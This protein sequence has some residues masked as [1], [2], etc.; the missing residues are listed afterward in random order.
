MA[1]KPGLGSKLDSTE[2]GDML[3][4]S[5]SE[6]LSESGFHPGGSSELSQ[7]GKE[8]ARHRPQQHLFGFST[9]LMPAARACGVGLSAV[10]LT[11]RPLAAIARVVLGPMA[12]NLI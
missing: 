10:Q 9:S 11:G 12:T 7:H 6:L 2:D 8:L 5:F 3:T 4:G 1:S